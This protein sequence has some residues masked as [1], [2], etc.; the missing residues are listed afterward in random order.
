MAAVVEWAPYYG[1]QCGQCCDGEDG[2]GDGDGDGDADGDVAPEREVH[3]CLRDPCYKR[4]VEPR[5]QINMF[6]KIKTQVVSNIDI[7]IKLQ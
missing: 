1:V 2:D 6:F 7:N 4:L 3:C 5:L